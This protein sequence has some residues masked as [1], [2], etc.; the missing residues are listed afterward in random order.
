ML[1]KLTDE[2]FNQGMSIQRF[3]MDFW[4]TNKQTNKF[5]A[6][7]ATN[8]QVPSVRGHKQ[9]GSKRSGP[10]TNRFQAFGAINKQVPSVRGHKQ[11]SSKRSGPQTN[12]FQA[13]GAINKQTAFR[14]TNKQTAFRATNKQSGS[15]LSGPTNKQTNKQKQG[16]YVNAASFGEKTESPS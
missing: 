5:Q 4:A 15:K 10:Q 6:F 9:T 14:A 2:S 1:V 12:R 13:F 7:G 8:K 16:S 3:L 11:T